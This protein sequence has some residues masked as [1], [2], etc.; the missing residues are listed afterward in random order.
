LTKFREFNRVSCEIKKKWEP[1]FRKEVTVE[2]SEVPIDVC[3]SQGSFLFTVSSR[4][5][6][7]SMQ[8]I[9]YGLNS[10]VQ[11]MFPPKIQV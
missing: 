5:K 9:S 2:A 3:P 11:N 7:Y 10:T 8:N 4:G 1:G 6:I